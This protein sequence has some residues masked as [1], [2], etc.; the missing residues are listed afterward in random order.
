MPADKE[1]TKRI[2]HKDLKKTAKSI[3]LPNDQMCKS[4]DAW[5]L[6]ILCPGKKDDKD[7]ELIGNYG[8]YPRFERPGSALR[9]SSKYN[10]RNLPCPTCKKPN[11]LT[12]ADQAK[13]YQC[14]ECADRAEG[15]Y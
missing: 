5:E 13:G 7:P 9:K 8:G 1:L 4:G 2:T 15:L 6:A 10:P 14:D 3:A 12:P 11:R